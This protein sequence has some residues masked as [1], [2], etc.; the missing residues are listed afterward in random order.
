MYIF[1]IHNYYV[2]T[3]I[4]FFLFFVTNTYVVM[5]YE[6]SMLDGTSIVLVSG[7]MSNSLDR[8]KIIM[9]KSNP[10]Y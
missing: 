5:D 2:I 9:L 1:D 7:A 8:F 10:S 6:F 4:I 3:I